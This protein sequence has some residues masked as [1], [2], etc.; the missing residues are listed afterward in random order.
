MFA[1][2][3][4]ESPFSL[5]ELSDHNA[6]ALILYLGL[7]CL[8]LFSATL[9]FPHSDGH[10]IGSDGRS[11][12]ST[13][14]SLV[15]DGDFD[16][17]N[18]Y[19]WVGFEPKP[20]T[21]TGLPENPFAIGMPLLWLPFFLAAH[22]LS[23]ILNGLGLGAATNGLGP[24]YEAAVCMAT[25]FYGG[26]AFLLTYRVLRHSFEPWP[27]L[28]A[29]LAMWGGTA[30]IYYMMAEPSMSH[31]VTLFSVSVFLFL[32]YPI[33]SERSGR[34]WLALGASVGLVA[35]V[36]WQDGILILLPLAELTWRLARKQL[37]IRNFLAYAVILIAAA[38]IVFS[39][40]F[41]MWARLYG[42]P[43]TIPQGQEFFNWLA[44]KPFQT[45]FSTRH[46]LITWHPLILIA[47]LGLVPLWRRDR[48][49]TLA[50]IFVFLAQLYLNSAVGRWW[51]DDA[52]G[53]R[54]F[55]SL[56][57]FLTFPLAALL[58]RVRQE[59]ALSRALLV[60]IAVL[61][62]SN[63]LGMVQF[64]LQFVSRSEALSVRELTVDR[65]LLPLQL[66]SM[67]WN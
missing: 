8:L 62:V 50:I 2:L 17:T 6:R 34:C 36:R 4:P 55:T 33:P 57:P 14:R 47:L 25:I 40:Q 1:G 16:F 20:L 58:E 11:Y 22:L 67:I 10:L 13:L 28:I 64:V 7:L 61:I 60:V 23:L 31:G 18:E 42:T 12:Y 9:F 15:F 46:G 51:A 37:A 45:L 52:F 19:E 59:K 5:S 48:A 65:F 26:V 41:V 32:W 56:I 54:R 35:L 66:L 49:L 21:V 38:L 24:V 39:P 53:G 27:S 29:I 30:A 3:L 44:P 43:L 63:M